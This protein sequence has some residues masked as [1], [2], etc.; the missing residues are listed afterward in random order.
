MTNV[1]HDVLI[2]TLDR[3]KLTAIRDQLDTL[4]DEAAR[5]KMTLREA[6]AFLVSREIARRD[7][8]RISMSSKLAQ[9]PFV[10]ELDGFDF[11][12]QPS[13]DQGQI[14]E[15]ATCRW[16]AHGDTVLFLGPP[17][18]GKT[19]LAVGLG[20]EAIRQNY[21]VQFVTAATLVAMLAKAHNDGSLDKQLTILSRPKLLHRRAGLLALRGQCRPPVLPTGVSALREGLDPDHLKPFRGRM[22][23][24]FW[25]PCRRHGDIGPPASPLD[26]DHHPGRQLSASR[27]AP[28]RPSAESR[29]GAP[30]QRNRKPMRGSVLQFAKGVNSSIRL[31][32]AAAL[33]RL[34]GLD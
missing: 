21:N 22:G 16:I 2:A 9:F 6:L 11:E 8:R 32:H 26:G 12:A 31:T 15:L 23:K 4:L 1:D 33:G 3:L 29:S 24:C 20:R 18:T 25:R 17:G 27:K 10:R 5:S 14:R 28:L 19:H 34:H 30:T 13:L 7:E